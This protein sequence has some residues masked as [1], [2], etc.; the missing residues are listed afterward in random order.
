MQLLQNQ[1][2]D[3]GQMLQQAFAVALIRFTRPGPIKNKVYEQRIVEQRGLSN[4]LA[5]YQQLGF[6]DRARALPTA[7]ARPFPEPAAV[8]KTDRR[9]V[10]NCR[11]PAARRDCTGCSAQPGHQAPACRCSFELL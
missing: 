3:L 4:P 2:F 9:L 5:L 7:P 10:H 6:I 8:E 11:L 1:V